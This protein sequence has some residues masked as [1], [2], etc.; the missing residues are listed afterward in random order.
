M[1]YQG[2]KLCGE[3]QQFQT[4][5]GNLL[6]FYIPP[7]TAALEFAVRDVRACINA[8]FDTYKAQ[9]H[10]NYLEGGPNTQERKKYNWSVSQLKRD[11]KKFIKMSYARLKS[12]IWRG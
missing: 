6:V 2:I 4:V 10:R 5:V 12:N 11:K 3:C 8:L 9:V 7:N 1:E